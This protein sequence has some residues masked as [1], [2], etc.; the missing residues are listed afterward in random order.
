MVIYKT[1]Q[2]SPEIIKIDSSVGLA[3]FIRTTYLKQ[4]NPLAI[5]ENAEFNEEQ[6]EDILDAAMSFNVEVKALSYLA[7]CEQYRAGLSRKLLNKKFEKKYIDQ[8]L[9]YLEEKDFLNDFRWGTFW[10]NSRKINHFEGRTKLLSELIFRG[11]DKNTA[12]KILDEY[13]RENDEMQLCIKAYKKYSAHIHS[14]E[15]ESEKIVKYLLRQGF[16]IKMI[17]KALS[18]EC[19][20]D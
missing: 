7:R 20:D 11:I 5:V 13:F 10:V 18:E 2:V 6:S 19:F 4:V 1:E 3:F 9:N 15:N 17:K 8:V 14:K 16:P 12:L